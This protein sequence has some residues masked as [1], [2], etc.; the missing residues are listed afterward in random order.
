MAVLGAES[1]ISASRLAR[2]ADL[3]KGQASRVVAGLVASGLVS[4]EPSPDHGRIVHLSLTRQGQ[5]KY[6]KL[7]QVAWERDHAFQASLGAEQLR[8]LES[9]LDKLSTIARAMSYRQEES[10]QREKPAGAKRSRTQAG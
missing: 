8:V 10:A 1:P 7:M 3:D 4:R 5:A 6:K 2:E 9:A